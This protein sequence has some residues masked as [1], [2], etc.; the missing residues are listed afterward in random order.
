MNNSKTTQGVIKGYGLMALLITAILFPSWGEAQA[1]QGNLVENAV[2]LESSNRQTDDPDGRTLISVSDE[3]VL[4]SNFPNPVTETSSSVSIQAA[5]EAAAKLE[6]EM[7]ARI[8][9]S[10]L[11]IPAA[12]F[13]ADGANPDSSFFPFSGGYTTGD[14]ENYGCMVAPAYLPNNATIQN[15]Y[16]SVYDNDASYNLSVT[17]R[18]VDNFNGGTDTM[19]EANT[20][21]EYSSVRTIGDWSITEPVVLYPDYSYFVTTCVLS[22]NIRLYSVRLY[23]TEP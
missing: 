15:M 9:T 13:V 1:P 6:T 17:L 23:Y 16:V 21:G 22:N 19:A 5:S 11:V 4:T 14:S 7:Q 10:P 18:R 2:I 8:Y 3:T 12:E 20:T